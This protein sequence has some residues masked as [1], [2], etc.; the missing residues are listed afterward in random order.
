VFVADHLIAR[1]SA[2]RSYYELEGANIYTWQDERW[3]WVTHRS[4]WGTY[5]RAFAIKLV[6]ERKG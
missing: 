1:D 4:R 5:V 2:G 3:H 6:Y